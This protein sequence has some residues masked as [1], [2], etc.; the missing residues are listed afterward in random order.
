MISTSFV[1]ALAG[2]AASAGTT[3]GIG[4]DSRF[5]GPCGLCISPD[6]V[7][8]LVADTN[9]QLIRKIIL[10]TVEVTT[11][12]GVAGSSGAVDG[13]GTNSRFRGPMDIFISPDGVFALVGDSVNHL[14]RQIILTT[15][16]VKTLA[17]T[18]ETP[19]ST[20][21]IGTNSQFNDPR[22]IAISPDGAYALV[23]DSSNH[24]LR[25]IILSTSVIVTFAGVTGTAGSINGV[26]TNSLLRYPRQVAISPD[27]IYG[28]VTDRDSHLIRKIIISTREVTTVAGVIGSCGSS[29]GVGT[30]SKFCSPVGINI[31]PDGGYAVVVDFGDNLIRKLVLTSSS[32]PSL[33]PSSSPSLAPSSSPSLAPSSSPSLA[34]SSSPSLAPSSSPSLAPPS[35]MN[36]VS[37][38]FGVVFGDHEVLSPGRCLQVEYLRDVRRGPIT[39]LLVFCPVD[40]SHLSQERYFPSLVL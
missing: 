19:G 15:I 25:Q 14:I 3:N 17:G 18:A 30:N 1:I 35:P 7:Y 29:N 9:N 37:Y 5:S 6:E 34:P 26:G 2:L 22:G 13:V 21:G 8:A 24:L 16:E 40:L 28:L 10:S 20:N 39:S 33:A 23:A 32:S 4:T 27:G 38:S 12:A 11:F 31:S 36:V